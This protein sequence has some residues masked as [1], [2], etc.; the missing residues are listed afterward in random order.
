ML[1]K[2]DFSHCLKGQ[3]TLYKWTPY[4][5]LERIYIIGCHACSHIVHSVEATKAES[6][7]NLVYVKL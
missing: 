1:K 7:V 2:K 3:T 4:I 6:V 5:I